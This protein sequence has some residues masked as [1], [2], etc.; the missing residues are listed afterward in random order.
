MG[1]L[2]LLR[3]GKSLWNMENIFTGWTDIDLAPEGIEEAK[4]A[5]ML[6]KSKK[7][8]IDICFSSYLKRAIRTAWILLDTADMMHVDCIHSWKLNERHYGTWQGHNKDKILAD[9]GQDL[10]L[11]IRRGYDT[12]P[13]ALSKNDKRH[14]KFD[15]KYKKIDSSLLPLSESLKDTEKRTVNYFYEVIVPQLMQNKTVLI[16]AHGNSLRALKEHIENIPTKNIMELNVPTGIPHI[17]EFDNEMNLL[18]HHQL[19]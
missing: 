14:P 8:Y 6:I 15:P 1:K 16:S 12:P 4:K 7:I 5:G 18:E 11:K 19:I 10:F 13:P 2:I 9:V 3:H 17:Y